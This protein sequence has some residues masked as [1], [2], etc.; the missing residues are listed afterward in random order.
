M[1]RWKTISNAAKHL[2]AVIEGNRH[3]TE[4]AETVAAPGKEEAA[5]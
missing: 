4:A 3:N 1:N 2:V 5:A